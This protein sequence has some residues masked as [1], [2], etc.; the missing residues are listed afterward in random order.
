MDNHIIYMWVI[1]QVVLNEWPFLSEKGEQ[2]VKVRAP[3]CDLG[4]T[5][6]DK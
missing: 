4:P 5:L 1:M 3:G 6:D 2:M